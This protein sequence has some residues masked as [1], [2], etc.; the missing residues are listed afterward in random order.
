LAFA[1][2]LL[3]L[4]GKPETIKL[5]G[6]PNLEIWLEVEP[7]PLIAHCANEKMILN[8]KMINVVRIVIDH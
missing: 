4:E 6:Q 5:E 3:K 2:R 7:L 1:S 8:V